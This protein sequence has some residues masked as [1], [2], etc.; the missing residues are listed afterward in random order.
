MPKCV[1]GCNHYSCRN[2][3]INS[4][5]TVNKCLVCS[6]IEGWEHAIKACAIDLENAI[7]KVKGYQNE[8]EIVQCILNDVV[9]YV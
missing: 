8:W 4:G 6:E 1:A 7:K 9:T 5:L 3:K 2:D